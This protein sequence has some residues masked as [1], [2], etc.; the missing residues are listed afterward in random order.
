MYILKDITVEN[1]LD[2][3]CE[4]PYNNVYFKG[5]DATEYVILI[6]PFP[7][8]NV[9]F[10]ECQYK[11]PHKTYICFHTIMYILKHKLLAFFFKS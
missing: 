2:N 1:K 3:I 8:N 4:F 9:Y 10:K 11:P 5:E 6:I 7:Y